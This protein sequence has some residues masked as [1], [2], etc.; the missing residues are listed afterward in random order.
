MNLSLK[1]LSEKSKVTLNSG[2]S[3]EPSKSREIS[4]ETV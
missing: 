1:N 3:Y 4:Y 2:S